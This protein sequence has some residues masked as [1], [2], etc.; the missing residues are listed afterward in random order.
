M[1]KEKIN[2]Y[3]SNKSILILGFGREGKS[4]LN[5]I[6]T[7]GVITKRLAIADKSE[8]I[9]KLDGIEY[10]LGDSYLEALQEFDIIIKAPGISLKDVDMSLIQGEITS[11]TDLFLTY[12]GSKVIGITGTKGKSTTTTFIYQMLKEEGLTVELVGNI[13][14]PALDYVDKYDETKYFVYELSSHQ[15]ELVHA[16]PK[17]AVFLNLYE[18]HLDYYS[19]FLAYAN[20]KR[21][22]F[23]YQSSEDYLV[24]NKDMESKLLSGVEVKSKKISVSQEQTERTPLNNE[25]VSVLYDAEKIHVLGIHNLYNLTVAATVAKLVGVSDKSI[26]NAIEKMQPLPHRL[27]TIGEFNGVKYIDD[28]I[29]TIPEATISA[30]QSINGVDTVLIGGMDRGINY[31]NLVQYLTTTK[32]KNIILMY[33]SGKRVYEALRS[34][35]TKNNIIYAEDLER[36]VELAVTLTKKGKNC[37]LS[38]AA[39]SYGFFKNFEERGDKFKEFIKKYSDS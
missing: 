30:I 9:E 5:Y 1:L 25:Y 14:V 23:K 4:T 32:T 15:L 38:P 29:S 36:A 6:M 18:E 11:Q 22:I 37:L 28:S 21:N 31:D 39:A 26:V 2:E 34:K 8:D 3:L 20:A 16:S 12:G 10:F 13:G 33:D 7:S 17:I 35:H 19:S 24:Y 27:Q